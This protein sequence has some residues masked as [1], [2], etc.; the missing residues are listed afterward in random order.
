MRRPALTTETRRRVLR[1]AIALGFVCAAVS[2]C[3]P[4]PQETTGGGETHFL[5]PCDRDA[6]CGT[7]LACMCGICTRACSDTAACQSLSQTATC[8]SSKDLP[9]ANSC[10]DSS[11]TNVCDLP[12]V[13]DSTCRAFS[14]LL[15]C[16]RGFCRN[17]PAEDA[18]AS[19]ASTCAHNQVAGNDVLF[20]GDSFFATSHQ[21]PADLETLA[22]D[23]G[24]LAASERYR[25]SSA[26]TGNALALVTPTLADKYATA[27]AESTP[28][29][30]IMNGGGADV[31]AGSCETPPTESCPVI[32]N[33]AAA[34]QQLLAQMAADGVQHVVYVF[35]PDP[36]DE[37]VR[38][39]LD[40]LRPLIQTSC[41]TSA[42]ACTWVDLR[43][44]FAGHYAE[45]ILAD[46][47][48]PTDTGST[49]SAD[50]IWAAMQQNC[51]AQ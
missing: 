18:G 6:I 44:P 5:M 35:Y 15:R 13:D 47:L 36:V 50:A 29:V 7:T 46:G 42:V 37:V 24:A 12:C 22:H 19:D 10:A 31:L 8:V 17:A 32:T 11:A 26:L 30:V 27:R 51:I 48:N 1:C 20:L 25:D 34:A 14:N 16:D 33:A 40:V 21:I 43:T 49:A 39:K 38:A 45:Y 2:N 41:E 3:S 23:A 4:Q 9:E 28:K